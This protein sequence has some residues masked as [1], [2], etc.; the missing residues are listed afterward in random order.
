[1]SSILYGE[2]LLTN[3]VMLAILG[4][5]YGSGWLFESLGLLLVFLLVAVLFAFLELALCLRALLTGQFLVARIYGTL[6]VLIATL[7]W[8]LLEQA[9]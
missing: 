8:W 1:M 9:Q 4:I 2:V 5:L 3:G 7:D 6:F